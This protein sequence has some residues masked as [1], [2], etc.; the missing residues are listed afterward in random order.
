M[1]AGYA[2]WA[3]SYDDEPDNDTVAL[4]EPLVQ[5]ILDGLSPGRALDA[6]CGTGRHAAHLAALGHEVVGVDASEPMLAVARRKLPDADLRVGDLTALP[7]E[8]ASVDG[9]VCALALSHLSA[10][11]SA[12]AEL[13]RVLRPG[14]R[15]IVSNPHPL[16]TAIL[17]WRCV[18]RDPAT[19]VRTTVR[20]HPH[21]HG[22]YLD[23][24]AAAGLVARRCL[25]PGLTPQQARARG[26]GLHPELHEAALTGLPAVIVWEAE[27]EW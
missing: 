17:G 21:T 26:K 16:A 12:V 15:L 11:G 22:D 8:D 7:L 13:G 5:G 14:G 9:A 24:F 4:E 23:A 27:R 6:G 3:A 10:L 19:G 25:E 1:G 20:E 2:D 18:V